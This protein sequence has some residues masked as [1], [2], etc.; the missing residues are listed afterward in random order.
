[1]DKQAH[2]PNCGA[3]LTGAIC[4]YCGTEAY[5]MFSERNKDLLKGKK[6][7]FIEEAI[8][9]TDPPIARTMDGR[10]KSHKPQVAKRVITE[11][12]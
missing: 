10:L 4:E 12:Y 3:L 5:P 2:C 6:P 9:F 8:I 1:M 7:I 11:Y